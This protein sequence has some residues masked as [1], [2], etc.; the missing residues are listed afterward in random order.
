MSASTGAGGPKTSLPAVPIG[1]KS[2]GGV[3]V[4]AN[5]PK[6]SNTTQLSV[7]TGEVSSI[8]VPGLDNQKNDD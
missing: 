2:S 5:Q 6:G 1:T 8:G 7:P 4:S 3:P